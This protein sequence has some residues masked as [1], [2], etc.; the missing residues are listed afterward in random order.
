MSPVT[1]GRDDPTDAEIPI[2][3]TVEVAGCERQDL[4]PPETKLGHG[5]ARPA[6]VAVGRKA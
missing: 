1:R 6:L 5:P 4:V 3:V 2:P